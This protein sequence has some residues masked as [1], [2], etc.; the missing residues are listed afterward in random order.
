M[1]SKYRV[2]SVEA[3]NTNFYSSYTGVIVL[4][5]CFL[6][7]S[8]PRCIDFTLLFNHVVFYSTFAAL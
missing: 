4:F 1:R 8:A 2:F 3:G 7:R 6:L 5:L